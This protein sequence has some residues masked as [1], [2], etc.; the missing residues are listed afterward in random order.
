MIAGIRLIVILNNGG[1]RTISKTES[2]NAY[3]HHNRAESTLQVVRTSDVAIADCSY[4]G[5]CPIERD[6]VQ[7]FRR[8]LAV[9]LFEWLHPRSIER[10]LYLIQRCYNDP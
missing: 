1:Q 5:Y 10:L 6:G 3:D 2:E 7:V 9:R 8:V 4:G